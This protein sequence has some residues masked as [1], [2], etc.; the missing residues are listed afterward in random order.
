MAIYNFSVTSPVIPT[1]RRARFSAILFAFVLAV[2]ACGAGGDDS[3]ENGQAE[4]PSVEAA[5]D[6]TTEAPAESDEAD[7]G[8]T[9]SG[10]AATDDAETA[11][12]AAAVKR[13]RL[14]DRVLAANLATTTGRFEG[15]ITV[16]GGE[17]VPAEGVELVFTGS[18]D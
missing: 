5:S 6:Q 11:A 16:A 3:S 8:N 2:S 4:D 15:R 7:G 12:P 10:D 14:G 18:F 9:D 1:I 17:D 13:S